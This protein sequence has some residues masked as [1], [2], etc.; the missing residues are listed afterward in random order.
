MTRVCDVLLVHHGKPGYKGP[1][2]V[3]P[4]RRRSLPSREPT[5]ELEALSITL[6]TTCLTPRD[7]PPLLFY[8]EPLTHP[9]GGFLSLSDLS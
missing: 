1:L 2:G 4:A 5:T 9:Q 7:N 3:A 6:E 8:L